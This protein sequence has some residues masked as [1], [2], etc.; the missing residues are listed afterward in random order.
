[1]FVPNGYLDFRRAA[2]LVPD[3]DDDW[4][5][6]DLK[7]ERLGSA[8]ASGALVAHGV[9][10]GVPWDCTNQE[11]GRIIELRPEAWRMPGAREALLGK[12]PTGQL[13]Q[14]DYILA[15]IIQ[16][17][18]F[19]EWR[20]AEFETPRSQPQLST[21]P[22]PGLSYG[23][24]AIPSGY[25][26]FDQIRIV[27]RAWAEAGAINQDLLL[28]LDP[29]DA[30][31]LTQTLVTGLLPAF[32][33]CKRTGEIIHLPPSTWRMEVRG[34]VQSLWAIRGDDVVSGP[35]G[36]PCLPVLSRADLARALQATTIPPDP[37]ELPSGSEPAAP[38][39]ATP[40]GRNPADALGS[41][42]LGYAEG[43]KAH[44]H[45]VKRDEA[46]HAAMASRHCTSRQ[47]EAA[48]AALPYPDLRNP[49]RTL[50]A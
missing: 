33:I 36:D 20:K 37:P 48:Y 34:F 39:P 42:M 12:Q 26:A 41:W 27:A 47:A 35:D 40:T 1:M 49:P 9:V 4:G 25:V 46:V 23:V 14:D 8:L 16:R 28:L 21:T 13:R 19:L 18:T 43:F 2:A 31:S 38:I 24:H 7:G 11:L 17:S 50:A 5:S 10:V 29:P 44:G 6:D 32:G 45:L 15:P 3:C 30:D 22:M